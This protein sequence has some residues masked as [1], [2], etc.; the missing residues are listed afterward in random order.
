M[1]DSNPLL[2]TN[3][4]EHVLTSIRIKIIKEALLFKLE[5]KVLLFQCSLIYTSSL[6]LI[7]RQSSRGKVFALFDF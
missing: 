4:E 7:Y 2:S 1:N 3:P 6:F 5:Q